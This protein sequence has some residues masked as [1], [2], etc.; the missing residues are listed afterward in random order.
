MNED[1][2]LR[3][4]I[5][6]IQISEIYNV[7][8]QCKFPYALIKGEALSLQAYNKIGYRKI[9]DVDILLDRKDIC[10]FE[11]NLKKNK[12][13]CLNKSRED[14]IVA[15]SGSHQINPYYK[16]VPLSRM[17]VDINFDIFWGEYKGKRVNM[18]EFLSD[19]LEVELYGIK[20][21]ILPAIKAFIQ[22][23]LHHYKEMNSLY[24]LS[25][26]NCINYTMFR[27]IF[28]L[29][30]NNMNEI[31]VERLYEICE[32]MDIKPYVYYILYYTNCVFDDLELKKYIDAL[33]TETGVELLKLY[34]LTKIEQ[35]VWK[36]DFQTRIATENIYDLIKDDLTQ[37]DLIK[38]ERS[39]RIFG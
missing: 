34:G 7:L 29:W 24:H 33:K 10:L 23:V 2:M 4:I 20:I 21:R 37:D 38:I 13:C 8:K 28:F 17:Y 11:N 1:E 12:F 9:G 18:K 6:K 39:K 15:L 30:K 14:R 36:Y 31:S 22:L 25:R 5:S 26:H 16:K 32:K 35:K 3:K 27:D 19:T